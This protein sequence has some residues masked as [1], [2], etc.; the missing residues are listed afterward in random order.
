MRSLVI[1]D[2]K[3]ARLAIGKILS[4]I[5]FEIIEAADG[6]DALEKLESDGPFEVAMVDW[7]MPVM[8]GYDFI[9]KVR[10]DPQH[11]EMQL[12]MVTTENESGQVVKALS[13]GANEYIMKP[14]TDEMVIEKL[15]VLGLL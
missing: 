2:S 14:F 15:E 13:A 5:G 9:R 12:V 6:Q 10:S 1:D 11:S 3:V 8:N 7:N 4:Q